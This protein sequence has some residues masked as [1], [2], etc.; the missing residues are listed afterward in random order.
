[1]WARVE[2]K[3]QGKK[4]MINTLVYLVCFRHPREERGYN[5]QDSTPF[6]KK[7]YKNIFK[8]FCPFSNLLLSM[9]HVLKAG[10][11]LKDRWEVIEFKGEGT[12]SKLQN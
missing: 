4:V 3:T 11:V 9:S 12:F 5:A 2:T 10:E 1:M 6:L 8:M 7:N